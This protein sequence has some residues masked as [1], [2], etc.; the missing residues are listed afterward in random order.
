MPVHDEQPVSTAVENFAEELRAWR[1]RVGLSQAELGARMGYSGSHVS[2]VETMSRTPTFEL[3]KKADEAL[4]TPGTFKRLHARITKE[5]HPPWFAPF[6]HFEAMAS[7]IHSW[8]NRF[9]TGLLQTEQYA[10]AIIRAAK[11]GIADDV[12]DRDVAARMERQQV[13]DRQEPPFCWFV[14]AESALRASFGESVVM[15]GQMDHLLA[16]CQR[17]AIRMQVWPA[18]V[19]DCPGCDGPVTVFDLPDS[20]PV[21]YAEGYEAGRIIESPPEMAKL[22]LL[23]DLLRAAALSP[24]ESVRLI[25]AIRGEYDG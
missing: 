10:R 18:D 17:P 12:I 20:G 19:P 4:G 14:I 21:G 1:E 23:F 7:R 25:A 22:I 8:D 6:V 9:I 13:L 11:A 3:A 15:R 2:S 24:A 5:A 16:L